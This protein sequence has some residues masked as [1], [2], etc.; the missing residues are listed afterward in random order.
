MP[1]VPTNTVDTKQVPSS[2]FGAILEWEQWHELRDRLIG[3]Q[4][5]FL[6]GPYIRFAGEPGEQATMFIRDPSG[7]GLEFKAFKNP[8]AL[9]ATK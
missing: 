3:F 1:E 6:I 5:E 9:F 7:N 2:H 8:A 4:M